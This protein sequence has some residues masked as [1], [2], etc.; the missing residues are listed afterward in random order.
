METKNNLDEDNVGL[1]IE[2]AKIGFEDVLY[3]WRRHKRFHELRRV[4][5]LVCSLFRF[6][7]DVFHHFTRPNACLGLDKPA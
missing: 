3:D 5:G 6:E 2:S 7:S 1:I 4:G